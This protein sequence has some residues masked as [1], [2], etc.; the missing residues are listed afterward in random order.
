MSFVA[1]VVTASA[2]QS[3]QMFEL[4]TTQSG[5]QKQTSLTSEIFRSEDKLN[6]Y[7]N[8]PAMVADLANR[9]GTPEN[10]S[11]KAESLQAI[12]SAIALL[13]SGIDKLRDLRTN[14]NYSKEQRVQL[15]F[16]FGEETIHPAL[17]VMGDDK[18]LG[19][20]VRERTTLGDSLEQTLS[21]IVDI[22]Q[23]YTESVTQT[24]VDG[25]AFSDVSLAMNIR[26]LRDPNYNPSVPLGS[27]L[28]MD[29]KTVDMFKDMAPKLLGKG[30]DRSNAFRV[31]GYEFFGLAK[32][33]PQLDELKTDLE[34]L[35]EAI[36]ESPQVITDLVAAIGRSIA[37]VNADLAAPSAEG[38]DPSE[39]L[40][41]A[42]GNVTT[43][44]GLV[45]SA[46]LQVET[47]LGERA[48]LV[49][50]QLDKVKTSAAALKSAFQDVLN[51][52][53]S[54][55]GIARNFEEIDKWSR[56]LDLADLQPIIDVLAGKDVR[57]GDKINFQLVATKA[58]GDPI[59][60]DSEDVRVFSRG[61]YRQDNPIVIYALPQS[62]GGVLTD[63]FGMG[64]SAMF[65]PEW[66]RARDY[67]FPMF[68]LGITGSVLNFDED[69]SYE[70][71]IGLTLGLFNNLIQAGYGYNLAHETPYIY[72]GLR[73]NTFGG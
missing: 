60:L 7:F 56:E 21:N 10:L 28:T 25:S 2:N 26:I 70:F 51:G 17:T 41:A 19:P 22:A 23:E 54:F 15:F 48:A 43:L 16:D 69:G 57:F 61:V 55:L 66:G 49:S 31:I 62:D 47:V 5:S 14:E 65:Y 6:I 38:Q 53:A 8:R 4:K 11:A 63:T 40:S 9:F 46:P 32:L 71:G 37:V 3:Q 39:F 20:I 58:G 13:K 67:D 73:L 29:A 42:T 34:A 33:K 24:I 30:A 45:S 18:Q 59:T 12:V 52:S 44:I 1:L 72:F 50:V 64:Q 68:G 35:V 27:P 36:D